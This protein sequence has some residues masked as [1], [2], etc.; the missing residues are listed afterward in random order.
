MPTFQ[1]AV[2]L[3]PETTEEVLK[4][5]KANGKTPTNMIREIVQE[6]VIRRAEQST[7]TQFHL[8]EKRLARMEDRFVAWLVKV[9]KASAK[10]LFYTEQLALF[11]VDEPDQK[12]LQNAANVY[13]RS[14]LQKGGGIDEDNSDGK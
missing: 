12:R 3:S 7:D 6:S 14:F 5:A 13:V 8:V 10:G 9:S 2:R 4:L 11:E 1:F